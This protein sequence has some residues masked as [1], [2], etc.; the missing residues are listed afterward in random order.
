MFQ[1]MKN[2]DLWTRPW[3]GWAFV[4]AFSLFVFFIYRC[5]SLGS[6][7]DMYA[8]PKDGTLGL[9]LG[10]LSLG[11]LQDFVCVTYFAC[12]LWLFDTVKTVASKSRS[13]HAMWKC[14]AL[15]RCSCVT[16]RMAGNI[17]I[18]TVSWLLFIAM[19]APFVAD[20]LIVHIR[21]MR[22]SFDLIAMAVEEKDHI[23]ASPIS[24][25]EVNEG[26]AS[27]A[28][29]VIVAKV[30]ATIRTKASWADLT[31]W[32]PTLALS[33]LILTQSGRITK[34]KKLT[35]AAKV[36]DKKLV[37]SSSYVDIDLND[38]NGE[39]GEAEPVN[40]Y[41]DREGLLSSSKRESSDDPKLKYKRVGAQLALVVSGL[42]LLPAI[43]VALSR[44]SSPLLHM[45]P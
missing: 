1:R 8:G 4:Y 41:E 27:A 23:S 6:L 21:G 37:K 5:T 10:A 11:F 26:Y 31:R 12:A 7:F 36:T 44:A 17:A 16:A 42:V 20:L 9:A 29:L 40:A 35:R 22:F 18:F 2:A 43:V 25:D 13:L 38:D 32:N 3:L 14:S 30:F 39:A 34:S 15:V 33:N 19:M 28:V 45:L 24:S